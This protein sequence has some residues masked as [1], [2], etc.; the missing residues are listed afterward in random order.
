MIMLRRLII[1][2]LLLAPAVAQAQG[3]PLINAVADGAQTTRYSL[4][5]E[6]VLLM[7]AITLLPSMLL[8]SESLSS[9][10]FCGKHW[11][12]ARRLPTRCLSG[13]PFS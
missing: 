6:I 4:N 9:C 3:V 11:E 10:P 12:P 1:L 5:I 13:W 2:V 8:L 7:T